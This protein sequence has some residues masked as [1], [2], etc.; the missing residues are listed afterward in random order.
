MAHTESAGAEPPS[1]Y[2]SFSDTPLGSEI[3]E[4]KVGSVPKKQIKSDSKKLI[5][6]LGQL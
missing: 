2:H 5:L 4:F 1:P 3:F 6:A